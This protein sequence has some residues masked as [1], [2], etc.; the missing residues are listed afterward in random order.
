MA[1]VKKIKAL[2]KLQ[3]PARKAT[4]ATQFGAS[5][6]TRV[7][8]HSN[9]VDG[10]ARFRDRGRQDHLAAPVGVGGES[11]ILDFGGEGTVQGCDH[12]LVGDSW[13]EP[14]LRLSYVPGAGEEHQHITRM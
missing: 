12:D 9:P 1:K 2:I 3:V 13:S 6:P 4:P 11:P 10:H 8:H 14:A 5:P 7:D